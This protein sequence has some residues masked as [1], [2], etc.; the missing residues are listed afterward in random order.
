MNKKEI[1]EA[2]NEEMDNKEYTM[3][4][5]IDYKNDRTKITIYPVD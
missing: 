3:S 2:V 4:R 1:L 5:T